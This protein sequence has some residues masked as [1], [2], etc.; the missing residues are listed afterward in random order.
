MVVSGCEPPIYRTG[1][2]PFIQL[3]GLDQKKDPKTTK[4]ENQ[5]N[6]KHP[7]QQPNNM[8]TILIGGTT[9][10]NLAECQPAEKPQIEKKSGAPQ[11][12]GIVQGIIFRFLI[13]INSNKKRNPLGGC[14]RTIII[15]EC[16]PSV[17][18]SEEVCGVV[19][20]CPNCVVCGVCSWFSVLH[21]CVGLV[22][23]VLWNHL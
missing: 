17:W 20:L 14:A 18:Q 21:G 3:P 15:L 11:K 12:F 4:T 7:T 10:F 5:H 23:S 1:L 2:C 6:T 22:C 19:S 9:V 16:F 8:H 13:S